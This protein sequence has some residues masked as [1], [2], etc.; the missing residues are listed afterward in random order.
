VV[1]PRRCGH[2]DDI[3]IFDTFKN[4]GQAANGDAKQKTGQAVGNDRMQAEA[5][6]AS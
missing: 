5:V 3:G 1:V 6:P 4:K 2:N